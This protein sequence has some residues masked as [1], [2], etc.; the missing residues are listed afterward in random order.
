M[1][2]SIQGGLLIIPA[3]TTFSDG[4]DYSLECRHF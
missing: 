3:R 1:K 2:H 4:A